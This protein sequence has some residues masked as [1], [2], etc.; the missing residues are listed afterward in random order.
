MLRDKLRIILTLLISCGFS[1]YGQS[2]TGLVTDEKGIRLIGAN[3]YIEG[4]EF[5]GA[6]DSKGRFH[7][8]SIPPADFV[9][10]VTYIGYQSQRLSLSLSDDLTALTITLI[11]GELFGQEVVV[12]ARKREETIKEVPISMV[13]IQEDNDQGPRCNV[14]A[15]TGSAGTERDH[16]GRTIFN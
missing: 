16:S 2:V 9:L 10:V 1:I 14:T 8:E 3:V 13:A 4:T 11:A 15:R 6:T 12:T 7:I 5:G